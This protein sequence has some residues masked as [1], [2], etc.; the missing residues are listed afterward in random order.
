MFSTN[1][2][3]LKN[4]LQSFKSELKHFDASVFTVQETHFNK[5]GKFKMQ[6]FEIFESIRS[7]VK[8]GT[9]MGVHKALNPVLIEEY[10][11][12]FELLV[13]EIEIAKKEIRLITGY[14]PQE[15]WTDN[16]RLPFFIALEA[17]IVKAEMSN[18]AVLIQMDANSKLGPD[19]IKNDPHDQT[20]NGKLLNDIMIR[21]GLLVV[22]GIDS[23][24][25][26]AI[27]RKRVTKN[28]TEESII[29]FVI[30]SDDLEKDFESLLI[31]EARKHVL[32][33]I[34][35]TKRGIK[36]VKS[37]HNVL[38][39]KLK[40][41]FNKHI[42]KDRIEI[43]NLKNKECQE[44]FKEVTSNTDILSS[45]FDNDKDLNVC[46]KKFLKRLNG[47]IM[48]CF[49][50][51]RITEKGNKEIESL[52]HKR[53]MLKNK[54]DV[55]SKDELKNVEEELANKCAK[56][57]IAKITEEISGIECDNGGTN[58]GKLW[59]LRKKLCPKSRDPPTAMLDDLGNL[60]TSPTTIEKLALETYRKRLENRPIKDGL[61][62]F[63]KDKESLCNM[64]LEIAK[65]N[66]TKP[67]EL[68]D[69]NTV[70]KYLK[71]NKSR[72]PFGYANEIFRPE[73]AGDDLKKALLL[74]MNRI[75][76]EQIFPEVLEVC[77]ISSIYKRKGS[78]NSFSNYRGIFRLSIFRT[79][80][81]RLIYNDEYEGI[82]NNLTDSNVGARKSRN[83]RDNIFVLN[84]ITNSVVKGKEKAVDLQEYDIEKCFDALWLQ[85]CINDVFDAGLNND[86]L[87]L[88]FL[89][90]SNAKVA[91]KSTNGISKRIDIKNIIM[92]G[93]VWG[94][95][96]CTAT[97]DK[98]AQHVYDNDDLLYW[99]K[100]A[101]AIPPLGF[102]DDILAVQECSQDSVKMNA[103]INSFIEMKKLK[104]SSDKCAKIHIGKD[105][106]CCPQ[107]KTHNEPMKNSTKEKYLGDYL[108]SSGKVKDTIEE[109]VAKGYGIVAEILAMLEEIPLGSYRLDM[110]LKLRQAMLLNGVLFNSEAWHG[111][112][113]D[114]IHQLEKVDECLLRSLLQSHPKCPI[115]FLYLETGS[116]SIG[117]IV[118]SRRIMYLRTI[119]RREDEE[120]VKRVLREQEKNTTPGDFIQLVEDDLKKYNLAF[121]EE[122]IKHSK[123]E[124]F[125]ALV[126]KNIKKVAFKELKDKK[127][128]HSK[129]RNIKYETFEKQAYLISPLFSNEDVGI[130]CNLRSHTTRG[131]RSNFG[132]LY[133]N[134]KNCPL[135]CWPEN[136]PPC[137]DTQPHVLL[138]SK[139]KLE[140][141]NEVANGDIK[142]D[143]IY[144]R[145]SEQKAVVEMFR[146]LLHVRSKLLET[147][148][149]PV[150]DDALDPSTVR[151]CASTVC[152]NSND[153]TL[154]V[155]IGI[156]K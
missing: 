4:K 61:E 48:E 72:D 83:I 25:E 102:V 49:K 110:G 108:S 17:E 138:C 115:E 149:L 43:F 13:V 10:D 117:H 15:N 142:Y 144:G 141:N 60:V 58:S 3:G 50:K 27:T 96:F 98:L 28:R 1:A 73:V 136:S 150:G 118:S 154:N 107:L 95:L 156:L 91:V 148:L 151:C 140:S 89:E 6:D 103:V 77:D 2:A 52:F 124:N 100:G 134:D 42:K 80:L 21:H 109:R 132:Q 130:L 75:K 97:M 16:D 146:D 26:G 85:E 11:K 38:L 7:K 19:I 74:L 99:Y 65:N 88:L 35:R 122:F 37:D 131:I 87:P 9:M 155:R 18:K 54:T 24:C 14:G 76:K 119:L 137:L 64:R 57:N 101:V 120:L 30:I 113:K 12:D 33:K 153:C 82:D 41:K 63:Q 67:W 66:K 36:Q 104:F 129:V 22:N 69:L 32:T 56:D 55:K 31:D 126:Q 23:K 81:D 86:K 78:R 116:T 93:S 62:S 20:P 53:R 40:I 139:L 143:N 147:P 46:T 112:T 45:I 90:N 123:E 84:A 51:V 44:A 68:D 94:S 111:V 59:Q 39:S 92:Q 128:S 5:K 106:S 70:L 8:G 135:K 152:V 127:E 47:C 125:K 79:V 145:V 133:K 34:T 121:N 114:D 29:D 105:D 71:K